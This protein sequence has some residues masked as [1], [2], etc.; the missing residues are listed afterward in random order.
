MVN[1]FQ[2]VA[3]YISSQRKILSTY[4]RKYSEIF[5]ANSTDYLTRP[6]PRLFKISNF[7][8]INKIK[9]RFQKK[10]AI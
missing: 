1:Y 4:I 8:K 10:F 5:E 6:F 9:T 2:R 7:E 3:S